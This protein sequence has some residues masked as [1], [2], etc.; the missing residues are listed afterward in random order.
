MID[1]NRDGIITTEDLEGI[2][3]TL[4]EF[5]CCN[6]TPNSISVRPSHL[7]FLSAKPEEYCSIRLSLQL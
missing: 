2:Y 7:L 5:C 1:Q 3:S 4:G 6:N